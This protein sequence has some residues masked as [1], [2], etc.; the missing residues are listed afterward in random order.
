[1]KT[2]LFFTGVISMGI[3]AALVLLDLSMIKISFS[4]TSL[5]T[6]TFYPATFFGFMG[7]L[8]MYNGLKPLWQ[9]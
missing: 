5:S 8:L 7:L 3:A 6:M 9:K 2:I 4:D 1:M